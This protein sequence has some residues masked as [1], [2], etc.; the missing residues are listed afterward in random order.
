MS[1]TS[2]LYR[3]LGVRP[4]INALGHPTTLGG[5]TPSEAVREAMEEAT[6]DYVEMIDL[7]DAVGER[8]ADMLGV[9]AAMVTPGC[10]AALSLGAAA[11]IT[12]ADL[13]KMER[14]PD[15]TGMPHEFI[16]QRQLRV[17]Y[18]RALTIPGGR[19]VEVG[20]E[21]GTL[22][23]H[24]EA[25]I[26]PDTAG[27]H[28]LAGGL[29]DHPDTRT[30]SV[31]LEK[32]IEIAH[33]NG[34]PVIIDAAGQ[35]YPTDRLSRYP[36]MG[37]DLVCHGA[38]Y[39]GAI[40]SSGLLTGKKELIDIARDHSFIG[41]ETKHIRSFGRTMKMDRQS[42]VAVYAAL[43]EWLST[44]HEERLNRYDVRLAP[45][46]QTLEGIEGL[47][48]VDFPGTG[49]VEGLRIR[50]DPQKAGR[51]AEDVVNEL[52]GGDPK[53]W[54][55]EDD[56]RGSFIIRMTTVEEGDEAV[57]ADRVREIVAS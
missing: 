3:E 21:D 35:V 53:I 13:E 49:L 2:G 29:Y 30:D 51:S 57:I 43:R 22:P 24:I 14:I 55:R 10:A 44:D 41:F 54:V 11:C 18:D 9:E 45:V 4:V 50:I 5:N 32:V 27:I 26:G 46:R 34:L 33:S 39:F 36:Q 48:A 23:E 37:A 52:R 19:L 56:E 47:D 28:Y 17:I 16:I 40:N 8:I 42:V 15:V 20:E 7:M 25:A 12:G 6:T 1:G 38:K 31:S